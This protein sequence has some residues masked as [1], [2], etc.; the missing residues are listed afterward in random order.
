MYHMYVDSNKVHINSG[1]KV[2]CINLREVFEVT[3]FDS[4]DVVITNENGLTLHRYPS[5]LTVLKNDKK[6]KPES[7]AL[8]DI[9]AAIECALALDMK[10]NEG[11]NILTSYGYVDADRFDLPATKFVSKKLELALKLIKV[12]N[13]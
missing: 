1:D 4:E 13:E 8:K 7:A 6:S 12:L 11:Q 10:Y 3:G 2:N 5:H 9:Q